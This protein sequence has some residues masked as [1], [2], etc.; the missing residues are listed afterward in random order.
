[1]SL[2]D[3]VTLVLVVA[4]LACSV[5]M[6]RYLRRADKA[7]NGGIAIKPTYEVNAAVDDGLAARIKAM[8]AAT[9]MAFGGRGL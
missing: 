9:S 4:I 7:R 2:V 5:L 6:V 3:I 1:M 8:R